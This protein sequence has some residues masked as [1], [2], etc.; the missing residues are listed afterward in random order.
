MDLYQVLGV[1]R[2]A[3]SAEVERAYLRLARRYHPGINPGDGVSAELYRRVQ[4]AYAVLGDPDRRREYDRGGSAPAPVATME[5]A[6]AFQGFDFSS[7]AE[8]ASAATFSEL[9]SDVFRD[10]ARRVTSPAQGSSVDI[11]LKL[12][13]EDAV[14][15]GQFPLS[16]TRSERC[17][18]CA[19]TG[20]VARAPQTCPQCAG[21]GSLRWARGHMV[22]TK[23]CEKCGGT[24]QILSQ[25][26]RMCGSTGVHARSE[27]VTLNLPPG[28]ETGSRVSVPGR[29]HAGARG[30]PAGDLYVTVE[31]APHPYYQRE[32]RD[33]TMVLPVAVHEA[34]LGARV[35]VPTL[36]GPVALKIPAGSVT[37]QRLR[38]RGRGVP[39][40]PSGAVLPGDLVAELQI[41]L[42]PV[43]DER[44]KELLREFGRLNDIDVRRHLFG[45]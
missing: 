31:V 7:L 6:M 26:C 1:P 39:G 24:G 20:H 42:P 3:A 5:A 36:D 23:G 27:V 32:G 45:G 40:D 30:G 35:N 41:V 10:A 33:L 29:G 43:R 44:S 9:F 19:G 28:L 2:N 37:G 22:F 11:T 38:L 25:S 34:A 18:A 13:F 16:V 15:G 14:R 21:A 4:D 17:G 12:S 8:G